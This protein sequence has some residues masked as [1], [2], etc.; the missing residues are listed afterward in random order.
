MVD[1]RK[2]LLLNSD[3]RALKFVTWDRAL[4]LMNREKVEVVS[5]WEGVSVHS[6]STSINLPSTLRLRSHVRFF[7]YIPKFSKTLVKKRDNFECQYC[8]RT[9][10]RN[11]LT[12]DH[13]I[14]I[15]RG[16][17]TSFENCV[18]ACYKC[19]NQKNNK[20]LSEIKMKLINT[21]KKPVYD[22]YY[23]LLPSKIR[24][25]DWKMFLGYK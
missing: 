13:V 17:E 24:H 16:G 22:I 7:R 4:K 3:Y 2:I 21:P 9:P 1:D 18:A 8:G 6:A 11:A 23:G 5:L 14:P 12:L 10:G 19:N 15:S 20:M 25:P